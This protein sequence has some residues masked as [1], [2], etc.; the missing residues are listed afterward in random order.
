MPKAKKDH[1]QNSPTIDSIK[2]RIMM[3]YEDWDTNGGNCK[4]EI[5]EHGDT[6]IKILMEKNARN[7][8]KSVN[9]RLPLPLRY[10][11]RRRLPQS[12]FANTSLLLIGK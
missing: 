9:R 5:E 10:R 7:A 4:N 1:Y 12:L 11:G 8:N 2:Q 3:E 6:M